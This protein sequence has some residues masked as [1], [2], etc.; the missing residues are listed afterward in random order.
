MQAV[1]GNGGMINT[2]WG[3]P[4][5]RAMRRQYGSWPLLKIKTIDPTGSDPQDGLASGLGTALNDRYD[6]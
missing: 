3:R 2:S 4:K 5:C 1:I 6:H